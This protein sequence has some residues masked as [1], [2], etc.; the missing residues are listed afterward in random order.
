MTQTIAIVHFNTPE[1]TEACIRSVRKVGID[2]PIVILDNSD[3]RPFTKRIKGVKVLNNRK[4]QIVD[5]EAELAKCPD[6]DTNTYVANYASARHMMSVQALFGILPEGF[7]LLDSDVLLTKDVRFIWEPRFA[8]SGRVRF[9]RGR[10]PEKDRMLPFVCYINV[11][12]LASHGVGYYD[13]KR[14]WFLQ[15]GGA[16]NPNN[17]YDTGASLLEDITNGKPAL[18]WRNHRELEDCFVHYGAASYRRTDADGHKEWL[19]QH[20]ALWQ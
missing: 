5:F 7:I 18:W 6:R 8:A 20:A 15:A 17:L 4:G 13:P 3:A 11:P 2:W 12:L 14:C 19:Q 16:K 10:T 1:L 9:G